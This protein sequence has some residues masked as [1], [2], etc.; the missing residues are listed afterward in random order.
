MPKDTHALLP[1]HPPQDEVPRRHT[2]PVLAVRAQKGRK[3]EDHSHGET[4]VWVEP[5]AYVRRC[6]RVVWRSYWAWCQ[7][8]GQEG[9]IVYY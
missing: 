8:I 1:A 7:Q 6:L 2:R 4:I 3:H 5:R 9:V